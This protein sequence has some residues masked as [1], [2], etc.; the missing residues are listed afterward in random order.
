MSEDQIRKAI[1]HWFFN[2]R[3]EEGKLIFALIHQGVM[4]VSLYTNDL[5]W[6]QT[7]HLE[8][9]QDGALVPHGCLQMQ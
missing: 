7:L 6:K 2:M 3:N 4:L 5:F 8:K 1:F 9:F